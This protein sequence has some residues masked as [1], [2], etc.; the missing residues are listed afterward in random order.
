M[1]PSA[2]QEKDIGRLGQRTD[3]VTCGSPG[4]H[5]GW[6]RLRSWHTQ[7]HARCEHPALLCPAGPSSSSSAGFAGRPVSARPA[8]SPPPLPGFFATRIPAATAHSTHLAQHPPGPQQTL[9]CYLWKRAH[10]HLWSQEP[11]GNR[12]GRRSSETPEAPAGRAK[13]GIYQETR[14]M[15]GGNQ[16]VSVHPLS[17]N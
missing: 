9:S 13:A 14:H 8:R 11:G 6:R 1:G 5:T 15:R 4:A 2:L 16:D 17:C 7:P 3:G 10:S 12:D